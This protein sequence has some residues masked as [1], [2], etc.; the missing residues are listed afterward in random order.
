MIELKVRKI[1]GSLGVVL[2]E[3]VVERLHTGADQAIF[4]TETPGGGYQLMGLLPGVQ[5]KMA[6]V[7]DILDRY[8]NTLETLSK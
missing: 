1:G 4:L 5:D 3:D 6:A 2:P 7:D 8:K